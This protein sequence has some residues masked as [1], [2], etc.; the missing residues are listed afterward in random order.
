MRIATTATCRECRESFTYIRTGNKP[1]VRCE[2]CARSR[3]L[4]QFKAYH[5]EYRR[6]EKIRLEA[7][8]A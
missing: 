1:R 2:P 7:A 4:A 8:R 6:Q 5:H 3:K